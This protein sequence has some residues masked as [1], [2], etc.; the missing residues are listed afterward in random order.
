MHGTQILETERLVLR[1]FEPGDA[2]AMFANWARDPA[3]TR[4]LRWEAHPDTAETRRV[5]ADWAAAYARPDF[6]NWGIVRRADGVLMGAIGVCPAED[7]ALPPE[8]GYAL[9]RAFWG[10]GYA[11]EALQAVTDYMFRS[12]G[13]DALSCCH[14]MENPA[15]GRVMCHVGFQ[16]VRDDVY[17]KYNGMAIPCK[18]YLLTKEE[19]YDRTSFDENHPVGR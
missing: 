4:Y 11:T 1:P 9:G 10:R 8:P 18:C 3:V 13:L 14:A 6:Y 16:Y 12:E 2:E 7:A 19:F 5:L 17:H 15:S